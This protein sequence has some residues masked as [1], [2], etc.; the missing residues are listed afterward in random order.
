M[1][2]RVDL[3]LVEAA[4]PLHDGVDGEAPVVGVAALRPVR[5]AHPLVRGEGEAA[6]R[7][8]HRV[9]TLPDPRHL[10]TNGLD[11]HEESP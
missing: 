5:H 11:F 6:R 3:A 9:T 4:V 1:G 7:E 10:Q 2:P 8:H